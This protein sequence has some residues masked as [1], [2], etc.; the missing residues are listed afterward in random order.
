MRR[1]RLRRRD[2][3]QHRQIRSVS[4]LRLLGA[5]Q[6]R[7]GCVYGTPRPN[8]AAGR[9]GCR[10]R[11]PPS[12]SAGTADRAPPD[13]AG[14]VGHRRR[15]ARGRTEAAPRATDQARWRE[16][17][18]DQAGPERDAEPGRSASRQ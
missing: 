17:P 8:G 6:A 14:P 13:V 9:F 3:D 11:D 15:R 12:R 4:L 1:R 10:R 7:A 18:R 16:R 2:D 5:D